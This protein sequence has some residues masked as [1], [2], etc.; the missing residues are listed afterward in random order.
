MK[1]LSTEIIS[2]KTSEINVT[3]YDYELEDLMVIH[4]KLFVHRK[5]YLSRNNFRPNGM[6]KKM[7][8]KRKYSQE[9]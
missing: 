8:S 7:F 2:S 5:M 6:T 4:N 3:K 1:D 9:I